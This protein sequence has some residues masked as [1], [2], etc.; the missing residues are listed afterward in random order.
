MKTFARVLLALF[1]VAIP[2]AQ[3][4]I[5]VPDDKPNA[6]VC[7]N[8]PFNPKFGKGEWRYQLILDASLL[9]GKACLINEVAF[10]PC[11]SVTFSA[12]TF[13]MRM[14]HTLTMPPSKSFAT[15]VPNPQV[16]IPAG[17]MTYRRTADS[18]SGIKL[19]RPFAYDGKSH[20]TI[21]VRYKGGKLSGAL[22]SRDH[23]VPSATTPQYRVYNF[24]TG[25]YGW[26]TG[27]GDGWG[28]KVR[29]SRVGASI[30]GVGSPRIGRTIH[31]ILRDSAGPGLSYQVATSLGTGPIP[32]DKRKLNLSFDNLFLVSVKGLLP[33]IFQRYSAALGASGQGVADIVIPEW[34]A[35]VGVRLHSAFVT[36]KAGEPSNIKDVSNTFTFTITR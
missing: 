1:A 36:L 30:Q 11:L 28:L 16:V 23:Q 4:Q 24:G 31:L 20:L 26:H 33:T 13:E 22:D 17:S 9:G 12:T 35:L 19:S 6:G 29:L 10:A 8:F 14:S 15:N 18:W 2:V 34:A 27:F 7:N 25:A 3:S 5:H 21:E 32:I